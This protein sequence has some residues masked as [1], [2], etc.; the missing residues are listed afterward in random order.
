MAV[1]GVNKKDKKPTASKQT[2]E[3]KKAR[4][5]FGKIT[6]KKDLNTFLVSVRDG[7]G[8]GSTSP[9]F[10]MTAINHLLTAPNVYSL[11]DNE[12][13][14]IA[15]DIWLRLKGSG[16]QVKNPPMLFSAEEETAVVSED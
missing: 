2:T 10:G 5:K 3:A 4:E 14:E 15:R 9:I 1:D 6:N 12:N 7:M 8:D 11:L 16:L 13:K